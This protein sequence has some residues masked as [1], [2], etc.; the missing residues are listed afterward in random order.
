[1][2]RFRPVLCGVLIALTV[3]LA[4]SC[5][6]GRGPD[7]PKR[8]EA[9]G[10]IVK[11]IR[12]E[13]NERFRSSE[14]R[15]YMETEES[16]WRRRVGL[17]ESK[18][19]VEGRLKADLKTLVELY[20]SVGYYDVRIEDVRIR[21]RRED[22]DRAVLTIVIEEGEPTLVSSVETLWRRPIDEEEV[23][24][25]AL[26]L[27][28]G[29]PADQSLLTASREGALSALRSSGYA[30]AVVRES[31]TVDVPAKTA[32]ARFEIEPGPMCTVGEISVTGL[33]DVPKDLVQQALDPFVGE[34]Y[35][36]SLKKEIE[37]K[38]LMMNVFS[39]VSVYYE[40]DEGAPEDDPGRLK[41][42]AKLVE[43]DPRSL[44]LGIGAALEPDMHKVRGTA[45]FTHQNL[46]GRLLG[47]RLKTQ[48]GYA[49]LPT[50][51]Q[52]D[53]HGPIALVEP[54]LSKKGLLE[55]E[56]F[57]TVSASFKTDV[58]EDFRY[59]G[60]ETRLSVS[61]LFL[62]RLT[63][64]LSYNFSYYY[65]YDAADRWISA[66]HDAY[67]AFRNPY[68][69]AYVEAR[70][71]L[72]LTDQMVDPKNGAVFEVRY[73]VAADA[74]GSEDRYNKVTPSAALYWQ[75]IPRLQIAL[76]AETGLLLPFGGTGD[77]SYWSNY[78][79]G[80]HNTMRGW[81]GKRLAPKVEY[82]LSENNCDTLR[83]GG[84]TMVL[85]N[86]ELRVHTVESVYVVTFLDVG[87][88]Q[89]GVLTVQPSEWNYSVGA[90][91]R[92]DTPVGKVRFDMGVRV[93]N[94]KIYRSEPRWGIHLGLGEAF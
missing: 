45:V 58:E 93:N 81:G 92:F 68:R 13:G 55:K 67:P 87:D 54:S 62:K 12:F 78:F 41:I 5:R 57:W 8:V 18:Y 72:R 32:R 63:V 37:N 30:L 20:R 79:L 28:E 80:G 4:A 74:L 52:M 70:S 31:M 90:G 94:P 9:R 82:C 27:H 42:H 69:L 3:L 36:P 85:G 16:S 66:V 15:N 91:F 77:T 83:I 1:M 22:A 44:K 76:R 73:A 75:M 47:F 51:W 53:S 84:R 11:R 24:R 7:G 86:A 65:I 21:K 14:L 33:H 35:T 71:T 34:R 89:Y 23:V 48:G 2:S 46:F 88:V 49:F 19:L 50:F 6:R 43:S 61:R 26:Q 17:S 56:L 38:L 60:P 29:D 40:T 10:P 64:G 39:V 59:L 25:D